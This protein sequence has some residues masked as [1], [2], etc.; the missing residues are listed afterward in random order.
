MR[1]VAWVLRISDRLASVGIPYAVV[2][3][4]V[5]EED[6]GC[7]QHI[8][9]LKRPCSYE[10]INALPKNNNGKVTKTGLRKWASLG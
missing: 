2:A 10:F 5:A 6:E 7:V 3:V 8:A 9:R 1:S 4:R